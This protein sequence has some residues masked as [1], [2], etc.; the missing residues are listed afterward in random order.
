[1]RS[2]KCL[3]QAFKLL[4]LMTSFW[5]SDQ[6]IVTCRDFPLT[7]AHWGCRD[8]ILCWENPWEMLCNTCPFAG[9]ESW[10]KTHKACTRR[11][12]LCTGQS[13]SSCTFPAFLSPQT[14]PS[15]LSLLGLQGPLC[16]LYYS[17]FF[18][19]CLIQP[20]PPSL[21]LYFTSVKLLWNE[22]FKCLFQ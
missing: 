14:S 1:M 2:H 3:P 4:S 16:L 10:G 22:I 18:S 21:C 9:M 5:S 6:D 13:D 15:Q 7:L 12:L 20:F 17:S 19:V 11:I 8:G